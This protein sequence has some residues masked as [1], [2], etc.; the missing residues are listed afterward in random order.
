MLA[1]AAT[2]VVAVLVVAVGLALTNY[3]STPAGKPAFTDWAAD[4]TG[5]GDPD[6]VAVSTSLIGDELIFEVEFAEPYLTETSELYIGLADPH[7]LSWSGCA[8]MYDEYGIEMVK[9]GPP[10]LSQ[11][12]DPHV[13]GRQDV[14]QL[15]SDVAGRL[16]TITVPLVLIG[17]PE[18]LHLEVW[19]NLADELNNQPDTFPGHSECRTIEVP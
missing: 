7:N 10:V 12:V 5:D 16:V 8:L 18:V 2:A 3:V 13:I 11:R 1:V 15:D 6:I 9:S 4:P 17:D 19:A 14:G